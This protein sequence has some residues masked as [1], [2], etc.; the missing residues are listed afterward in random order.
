LVEPLYNVDDGQAAR[1]GEAL[2]SSGRISGIKIESTVSGT[3]LDVK[4]ARDSSL[5]EPRTR[6]VVYNL[7]RLGTVRF[8]FSDADLFGIIRS[9][10]VTLVLVVFAVM[11]ASVLV[12]HFL[13]QRRI[14]GVFAGLAYGISGIAGGRYD[15]EIPETGYLDIDAIIKMMNDMA[16]S[17]NVKNH[18]LLGMNKLLERRVGER[19]AEL[20]SALAEQRLLQDRLIESGKL[21]ALGQ[22]AAGMAHELNTPLGAIS[23]SGR[24]VLD[25]LDSK[26]PAQLS[27]L[28]TLDERESALFRAIVAAGIRENRSLSMP[29]PSR[30]EVRDLTRSLAERG[31]KDAAAIAGILSDAGLAKSLDEIIG[32]F[33]TSRD[34]AIVTAACEPAI[35]RRMAQV[36]GESAEKAA[37]VVSALRSYLVPEAAERGQV[38]DVDSD[39]AKVLTLMHNMLKHGISVNTSFSGVRVLGSS[40]KL[41][42]VWMNLIRNAAQAMDFRGTLTVAT[43]LRDDKAVVTVED[44]GSGI[45]ESIRDRIFEPFFTTKKHGDGMGLGLDIC[46]KIVEAHHGSISFE[47][48]PGKTVFT[49]ALP[50]LS[51]GSPERGSAD[52]VGPEGQLERG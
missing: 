43:A 16:A 7:I 37:R 8:C 14:N 3:I 48:R 9:I 23:S 2:V 35:A 39:I 32:L 24:I 20:E 5:I 47:S 26:V 4:P 49:V 45:A 41:S 6:D 27:L 38:V 22:L 46:K 25:Y 11:F 44:S 50:A 28:E 13:V 34:I 33:G 15:R 1:I 51:D 30:A 18:Q 17:I 10:V 40:D 12:N 36:I 21:S 19:T 42:Q 31:V 52:G 29:I